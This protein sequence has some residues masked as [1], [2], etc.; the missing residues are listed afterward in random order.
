M[1]ILEYNSISEIIAPLIIVIATLIASFGGYIIKKKKLYISISIII[2]VL[3]YYFT[4]NITANSN[5]STNKYY[6][7]SQKHFI[8]DS[9]RYNNLLTS[10]Y[11]KSGE[12]IYT[13]GGKTKRLIDEIQ[14]NTEN[15]LKIIL[16]NY[17]DGIK[18][19]TNTVIAYSDSTLKAQNEYYQSINLNLRNENKVL[20]DSVEKTR[21]KG[22]IR[23]IG[24]RISGLLINPDI[25]SSNARSLMYEY[26]KN[27]KEETLKI[28]TQYIK[29][30]EEDDDENNFLFALN[31]I[32]YKKVHEKKYF[33]SIRSILQ[34]SHK[35]IFLISDYKELLDN[36]SKGSWSS[37]DAAILFKDLINNPNV[38]FKLS[39]FSNNNRPTI[40]DINNNF[41]FFSMNREEQT[42]EFIAIMK[43]INNFLIRYDMLVNTTYSDKDDYFNDMILFRD[44]VLKNLDFNKRS[45]EQYELSILAKYSIKCAVAA[46]AFRILEVKDSSSHYSYLT[47]SVDWVLYNKDIQSIYSYKDYS[48]KDIWEKI[49]NNSSEFIDLYIKDKN[50]EVLRKKDN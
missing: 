18:K 7:I 30:T 26:M 38:R 28:I 48:N 47:N 43:I 10:F 5:E 27:N 46:T 35:N 6:S 1:K 22:I 3:G 4:I 24:I 40:E 32:L 29:A 19:A 11:Q 36:C 15:Q 13:L 14:L 31:Y 49:I 42:T 33:D 8:D 12:I 20:A 23:E 50:L 25:T 21:M 44:I 2:A 9:I 37:D 34:N 16:D 41:I 17:S 39:L 45:D